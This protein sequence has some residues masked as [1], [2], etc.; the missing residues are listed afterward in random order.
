MPIELKV[1]AS[2]PIFAVHIRR[3]NKDRDVLYLCRECSLTIDDFATITKR[4]KHQDNGV[5][6]RCG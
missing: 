3:E 1:H 6:D 4:V 5:C 2:K